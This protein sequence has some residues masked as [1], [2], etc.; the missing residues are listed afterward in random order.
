MANAQQFTPLARWLLARLN[1]HNLSARGASIQAGLSHS[2]FSYYLRGGR[3]S[4]ETCKKLARLFGEPDEL[5]LQL[6]GYIK[7]PPDQEVFLRRIAEI[8]ANWTDDEKERFLRMAREFGR[9]ER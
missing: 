2:M 6:A 9:R 7:A 8:T 4:P 5:V 3:P 1:E